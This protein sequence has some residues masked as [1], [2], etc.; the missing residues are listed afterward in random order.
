MCRL[1]FRWS[2]PASTSKQITEPPEQIKQQIAAVQAD[3]SA[4][5]EEKR[6]DLA[7]LEA[8]L[9]DTKPI[10]FKENI[11]LVLKYFDKLTEL[12]R[13]QGTLRSSVSAM[14]IA[15]VVTA[16]LAATLANAQETEQ[17]RWRTLKASG[18]PVRYAAL[19]KSHWSSHPM[20]L[21][22]P[23]TKI[24]ASRHHTPR[25]PWSQSWMRSKVIF[26]RKF[27]DFPK[28]AK[29]HFRELILTILNNPHT[30]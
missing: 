24:Q 27:G 12:M 18:L 26:G 19:P 15:V 29:A 11:A 3:K 25:E 20:L 16:M 9:K 7:Q 2:C 1:I 17:W 13:E 21:I 4:P 23:P 6:E 22:V 28:L 14:R 5:E 10:Q 8:A 30:A